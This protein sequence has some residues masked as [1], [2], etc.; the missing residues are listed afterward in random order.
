M[1]TLW[2]LSG[3]SLTRKHTKNQPQITGRAK[4]VTML[5]LEKCVFRHTL[6]ARTFYTSPLRKCQKTQRKT[7]WLAMFRLFNIKWIMKN[8]LSFT[9]GIFNNLWNLSEK[10]NRNE[11]LKQPL[12]LQ[13]TAAAMSMAICQI[14]FYSEQN[15]NSKKQ[16]EEWGLNSIGENVVIS[17][18]ISETVP[19]I[20]NSIHCDNMNTCEKGEPWQ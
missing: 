7:F 17:S 16:K 12:V 5:R 6:G 2:R 14:Y 19:L 4:A 11:L 15:V 1:W 8:I 20:T 10:K 9:K 18:S 3:L 13:L